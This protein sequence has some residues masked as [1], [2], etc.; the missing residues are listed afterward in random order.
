MTTAA[1]EKPKSHLCFSS[2]D[3]RILT[4][5]QLQLF[6]LGQMWRH[7]EMT[8]GHIHRIVC[9]EYG[10]KSD[11]PHSQPK[12]LALTT[13]STT[14]ARMTRLG[15]LIRTQYGRYTA[16]ISREELIAQIADRIWEV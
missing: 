6:I 12:Q 15:F 16:A 8:L 5:G 14:L 7:K 4:I 13:V 1:I 10:K 3:N 11:D 2:D 9:R